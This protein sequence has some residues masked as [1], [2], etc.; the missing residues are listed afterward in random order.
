M[1]PNYSARNTKIHTNKYRKDRTVCKNC[2]KKNHRENKTTVSY[3]QT[4]HENGINNINI[5]TLLVGHS[6][7][8][9]T[10]LMLKLLSRIPNRDIYIITKSPP[11]QYSISKIK[12]KETSDEIKPLNEYENS[13]IVFDD[14]LGSSNSRHIDQFFIRG[15]HKDLGIYS[16]SQSYFDLQKEQ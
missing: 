9:K 2:Y 4:K 10:Y 6:F 1:N 8:G 7:L 16:L 15:R 3:Q 13:I 5:R 12:I 11:E 14:S